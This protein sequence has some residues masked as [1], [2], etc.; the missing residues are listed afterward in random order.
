MS[1]KED[2]TTPVVDSGGEGP[3]RLGPDKPVRTFQDILNLSLA[4]IEAQRTRV[5]R[6]M[7]EETRT[8]SLDKGLSV[9]IKRL[10]AMLA[11]YNE[12]VNTPQ[13][14]AAKQPRA[15]TGRGFAD[16]E[17]HCSTG[18]KLSTRCSNAGSSSPC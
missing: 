7:A 15:R 12:L 4:M 6:A 13:A 9:E 14:K 17:E 3:A 5:A 8:G 1:T 10:N 11:T 16:S 2:R 18:C